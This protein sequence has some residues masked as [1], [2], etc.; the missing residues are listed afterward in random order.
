[1][2]IRARVKG[3]LLEPLERIDLPEGEEI[4][5]TLLDTP[6]APDRDAF[7]N[8]AGA[9]KSALD[10]EALIER[11]YQDRLVSTRREPHL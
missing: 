10:A 4:T 7:R 11:I 3:G 2:T 1:M 9:W 6:A 5:I 8:S